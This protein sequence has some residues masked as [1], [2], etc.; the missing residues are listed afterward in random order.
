MAST[1]FYSPQATVR[2]AHLI[3][4]D[5]YEGDGKFRYS[6]ELTMDFSDPK[7]VEFVKIL[8]DE[9]AALHGSRNQ[10]SPKGVPWGK[11]DK[12]D[13]TKRIV[14]F[15]VNRF[16]ND[17]GTVSKGPR[18][19]DA[20]KKPWNG[21]EIGNGSLVIIGFTMYPYH[22]K[23]GAGVMLQP[24]AVQVL[25]FVNREDFGIQA[26]EGFSEH[27]NGYTTSGGFNDEFGGIQSPAEVEVW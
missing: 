22:K 2:W 17:D 16:S 4:A 11:V 9:F 15:T 1:L 23:D 6:C 8:E 19:V 21:L 24:K 13:P 3:N 10:R 5:D 27:A 14:K 18:I 20:M 26:A 7:Y 12:E 25:S